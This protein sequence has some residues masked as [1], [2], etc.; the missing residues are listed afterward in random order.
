MRPS[1]TSEKCK[2]SF[3]AVDIVDI[4]DGQ[5][6]YV[7]R[8][9]GIKLFV[10][11]TNSPKLAEGDAR[12]VEVVT[13][14]DDDEPEHDSAAPN[15]Q[16]SEGTDSDG[17]LPG[18]TEEVMSPPII[19]T[20]I[21]C[22]ESMLPKGEAQTKISEEDSVGVKPGVNEKCLAPTNVSAQSECAGGMP[23]KEKSKNKT[24]KKLKRE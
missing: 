9:T 20:P 11:S 10:A 16:A 21:G 13:K 18:S 14:V 15:S 4:P 23:L 6:I 19:N 1:V 12:R 8:V 3:D 2:R 22:A 5:E 7:E 17:T 24:S